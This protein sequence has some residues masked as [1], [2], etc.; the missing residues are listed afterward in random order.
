[1]VT[2]AYSGDSNFVAANSGVL[3]QV[4]N[5]AVTLQSFQTLQNPS[6]LGR[7]VMFKVTVTSP[8]GTPTGAVTLMKGATKLASSTLASGVA[9]FSIANLPLGSTAITANY[10]GTANFAASSGSITQVVVSALPPCCCSSGNAII[11]MS[12]ENSLRQ[13]DVSDGPEMS[14]ILD[15][16]LKDNFDFESSLFRERIKCASSFYSLRSSGL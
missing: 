7:A 1:L 3:F 14:P 2:A 6:A 11:Q 15:E 8:V 5:K 16:A 4:V 13:S 10:A 9:S 12:G